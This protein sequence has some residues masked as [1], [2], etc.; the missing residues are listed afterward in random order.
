MA[1]SI[2]LRPVNNRRNCAAMAYELPLGVYWV[3]G[4]DGAYLTLR[5]TEGPRGV[6]VEVSNPVGA[7]RLTLTEAA[8]LRPGTKDFPLPDLTFNSIACTQYR[9]DRE[10]QE[11]RRAYLCRAGAVSE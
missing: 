4:V 9:L 8:D 11:Y 2:R 5:V 7:P 10:S 3:R 1:R 6:S